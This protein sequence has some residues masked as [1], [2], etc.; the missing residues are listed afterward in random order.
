MS[1]SQPARSLPARATVPRDR[2]RATP[3]M[4]GGCR[5][6]RFDLIELDVKMAARMAS[7]SPAR[8]ASIATRRWACCSPRAART[9]ARNRRLEAGADDYLPNRSSPR[10]WLCGSTPSCAD[11]RHAGR[12]RPCP[13][14]LHPGALCAT[15]HSAPASWP[16]GCAGAADG[17][18]GAADANLRRLHPVSRSAGHAWSGSRRGTGTRGGRAQE[19][20]WTADHPP[21]PQAGDRSEAAGRYLQDGPRGGYML[22]PD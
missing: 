3:P 4:R 20:A 12:C 8:C 17:H 6:A 1:G 5:R 11:A 13:S 16:R 15:D 10:S 9:E 2:P 21:A 14:L 18:R 19:R 7:A 22:A